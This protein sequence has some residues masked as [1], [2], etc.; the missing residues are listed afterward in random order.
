MVP[1]RV[2]LAR[3]LRRDVPCRTAYS[4]LVNACSSTATLRATKPQMWVWSP[5]V[6]WLSMGASASVTSAPASPSHID[7]LRTTVTI[8]ATMP[9]SC[10]AMAWEMSRTLLERM[11]RLVPVEIIS[12]AL[13]NSP[14]SPTPTGPI[15]MATSLV[16]MMEHRM[17]ATWTPPKSPIAFI[18]MRDMLLL[19][20]AITRTVVTN[21]VGK[22][23]RR[24]RVRPSGT[25]V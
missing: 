10:P 12:R 21:R 4:P 17:P 24:C 18:A 5:K 22:C 14:K 19:L 13:L 9:E 2:T 8:R 1:Q 3:R 16:R 23:Y 7:H 11:P 15:H 25:F 20:P 6:T